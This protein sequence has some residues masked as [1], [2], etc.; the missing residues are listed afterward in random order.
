MLQV[1]EEFRDSG[2]NRI[3]ARLARAVA[4]GL[5]SY[6]PPLGPTRI[7]PWLTDDFEAAEREYW[8]AQDREPPIH[9]TAKFRI[10]NDWYSYDLARPVVRRALE[11]H[12]RRSRR[13]NEA[14]WLENVLQKDEVDRRDFEAAQSKLLEIYEQLRPI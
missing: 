4:K 7:N 14:V 13:S 6:M 9:G 12:L 10:L 11:L 8:A 1:R 5:R 3:R 2:A